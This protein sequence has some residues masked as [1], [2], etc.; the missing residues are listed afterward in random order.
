MGI[1]IYL[2]NTTKSKMLCCKPS[3]GSKSSK[4][5]NLADIPDMPVV[6]GMDGFNTVLEALWEIK[7]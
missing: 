2:K 5:A 1:N 6:E 4:K 3:D 7:D